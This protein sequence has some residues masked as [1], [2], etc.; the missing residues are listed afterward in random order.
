MTTE[1]PTKKRPAYDFEALQAKWPARWRDSG[2]YETK[3]EPGRPKFYCLDFF[4]Y[5]SGSGLSVGHLRNYVPTDVV[6]RLMNMKG[7][8]V[9]H[10]MGWDAFGLPA[11]NY[12]LKMGVHPR[13]TTAQNVAT[14][15]RQLA[16]V[17]TCYDWSK[18]L[19]SST[20]E[21]YHWTQWF[22]LLLFER[23]LAYQAEGQQW[24]CP[25]CMTILA[26][27]QVEDGKCWRH[28]E[29]SVTKK[30]LKQWYFKITEYAEPLL[31]D[32]KTIQW[33]DHIRKMQENWIGRSE[34]C[35]VVFKGVKPAGGEVDLPIFTTR[36]DTIFGV[37]YMV[38]APEHP[39]VPEL[40]HPTKQGAV[41]EYVE[42]VK[43]L[44]E[45]DRTSTEKEKTGV[46]L[47]SAAINPLTGEKVPIWIGDYV[48]A[49]YGTGAVMAVPGHDVRD[50]A[51]ATQYKLPVKEVIAP[52]LTF[53]GPG[54]NGRY[55]VR[56]RTAT[57]LREA[58]VEDGVMVQS[59]E[60]SGYT[61]E[62]GR[63]ALGEHVEKKGIGRRRVNYKFRDW[64]ISRQR[65][66][67]CPI[68]IVHCAACGAV[69]VPKDQL[70][71]MLPE[72]TE[73]RPSGTG[74]SPLANVPEFVK[75]TCPKCK[76]PAE[77]ETDTMDGFACSSWYFLRF[78]EPGYAKGPFDPESVKY[79]LPVDL[80]VGGA[81][82]A[83]MHLLYARFWTKVMFDAKLVHFKEPFQQ[84]RNQG[85]LLGSDG[86]KMSK[87]RGNVVTPDEVV[88][89]YGA[90]T[91]RMYMLFLGSFEQEAPWSDEAISGVFRYMHRVFDLVTKHPPKSA[92]SD[93]STDVKAIKELRF[94]TAKTLK[95]VGEDI[96]GFAFNTAV[97]ALREYYNKLS[98]L[99][100]TPGLTETAA[101]SDAMRTQL[102]MLAPIGP[103]IAEELWERTGGE[104]SVHRQPWPKVDASALVVDEVTYPIQINGKVRDKITVA[105]SAT[106]DD[107]KK[108]VLDSPN[109]KKW[110]EG[111][112]VKAFRVVPGR[113]ISVNVD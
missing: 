58:Y 30:S 14:Y 55:D 37:T 53:A 91:V 13:E 81:E 112:N 4:P 70:P 96:E 42:Q 90:D 56:D 75:T 86:S 44:S 85:M 109:V 24:W 27:E 16:L 54:E 79:W 38:L 104:G 3:S 110:T 45:I 60:F 62:A 43:R 113:L 98:S 68:P 29:T 12:A 73:F 61:S 89:V 5:P 21:Y 97:A 36:V 46:A 95:K 67:G 33:P 20:P 57:K 101:W 80:Y 65:Y 99:S 77:R 22:F 66:W 88:K 11:E 41:A 94:W 74:R 71:V 52:V 84:L 49:T 31:N 34:G 7:Y 18:E 82:H 40:T 32:L 100:A 6:S 87:S 78:P 9:L 83:V 107:L 102:V 47:G 23:G 106:E 103:F 69:A 50:Y 17:E 39:L 51:F 28:T 72:M 111:K 25:E 93:G 8:N 2:L 19:N 59:K 10:P 64:L 105:A 35:E 108:I 15:K 26:N 63:S 48:L 76:G 1:S 92:T